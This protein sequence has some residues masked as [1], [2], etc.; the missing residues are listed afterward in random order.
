MTTIELETTSVGQIVAEQ[1]GVARIFEK[2][3]IDYCCQGAT[4]LADA[5]KRKNVDAAEVIEEIRQVIDDENTDNE[6]D[7]TKAPLTE[8]AQHIVKT[9]HGFLQTELPRISALIA[10]VNRVHGEKHPEFAKVL[11]TFELMRG[12]LQSHMAKE[13]RILFP[14]IEAMETWQA[15]GNLPFG[16]VAN[17][18]GMMEHEHDDA[19][20]AL[21]RLRE[22]TNDYT[23]P[24]EACTTWRVMLEALENLEQDMHRHIH[25]ENSILF[26]RAI[27]LETKLR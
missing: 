7:W 2:H 5:C 22:L 4:T 20:N 26:P 1:P 8:L 15:V 13:E 18:I 3:K 25:K 11:S 14:A 23:P 12:E 17:P 21:Q 19:G 24:A 10:K 16:S 27:E 9:H 6:K